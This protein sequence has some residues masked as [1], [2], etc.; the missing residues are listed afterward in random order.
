MFLS[1]KKKKLTHLLN[2]GIQKRT[3]IHNTIMQYFN[4]FL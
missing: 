4:Y 2:E 3:N 1:I